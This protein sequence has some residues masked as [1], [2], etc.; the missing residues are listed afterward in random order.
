MIRLEKLD[1]LDKLTNDVDFHTAMMDE[2]RA[3]RK[4]NN[5]SKL[6]I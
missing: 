1:K 2:M 5:R 4:K 3:I 6:V